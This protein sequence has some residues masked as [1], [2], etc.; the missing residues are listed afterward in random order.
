MLSNPILTKG[1]RLY[2]PIR[3]VPTM[4]KEL[5]KSGWEGS[6]ATR[7]RRRRCLVATSISPKTGWAIAHHPPAIDAPVVQKLSKNIP[8]FL[9]ANTGLIVR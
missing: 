6:N 2:P 4:F 3:F 1:C 9:G 8:G 5:P 7:H